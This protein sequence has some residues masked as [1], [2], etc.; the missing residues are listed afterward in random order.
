MTADE[1]DALG[2][3]LGDFAALVE[4]A[5]AARVRCG[6]CVGGPCDGCTALVQRLYEGVVQVAHATREGPAALLRV[7][8]GPALVRLGEEVGRALGR[9]RAC[10]PLDMC[11]A[12]R[13][14]VNELL[15]TT[16]AARGR[17]WQAVTRN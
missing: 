1:A 13:E 9:C 14:A 17:Y 5:E 10:A 16:A 7:L 4:L 12:C 6:R 11:A 2:A 3:A 15:T 8:E